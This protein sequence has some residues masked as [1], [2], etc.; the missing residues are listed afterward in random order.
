MVDTVQVTDNAEANPTMEQQEKIMDAQ[1]QAKQNGDRPEWLPEK[2]ANAEELAKAYSNLENKLGGN[3]EAPQETQTEEQPQTQ[4]EL[5]K[6]TG[7]DLNPFYKEFEDNGELSQESF[8]TLNTL[9]LPKEVVETYIA[10]QQSIAD[11]MTAD[12]YNTVGGEQE[13][14]SMMEWASNNLSENDIQA[15][16]NALETDINSAKLTLKGIQAQYTSNN[17]TNEPNLTQ[18]QN[19]SGR[20]DIFNSTAEIVNAINDKRY[21]EDSHYRNQV[22]E[23]IKRSKVL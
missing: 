23:K 13:Y 22:E 14:R 4:E 7:L 8:E 15:Y 1:E 10:G 17:V 16:N 2:F 11:S 19:T 5:E 9:G 18:G 6:A 21:A 20:A 12:I 3:E